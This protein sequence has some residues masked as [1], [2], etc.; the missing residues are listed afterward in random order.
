MCLHS[1]GIALSQAIKRKVLNF[2]EGAS[3]AF[4]SDFKD[5]AFEAP[6]DG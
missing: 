2:Y 6:S 5:D 3:Y 4:K 1:A